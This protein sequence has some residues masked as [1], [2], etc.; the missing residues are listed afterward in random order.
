LTRSSGEISET[1]IAAR[2]RKLFSEDHTLELGSLGWKIPVETLT[3]KENV[4]DCNEE[5]LFR[6]SVGESFHMACLED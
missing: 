3:S 5:S 1:L 4:S 6:K 2:L